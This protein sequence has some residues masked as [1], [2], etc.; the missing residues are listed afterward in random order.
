M[1]GI[2]ITLIMIVSSASC[3]PKTQPPVSSNYHHM[4]MLMQWPPTFCGRP[5][6][7]CKRSVIM[8]EFPIHGLWPGNATGHTP[9]TCNVPPN[10]TTVKKVERIG[11]LLAFFGVYRRKVMD[12]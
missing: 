8:L 4:Q 7:P 12:T 9:F 3:D 10:P 11:V 2:V 6:K 1:F 5:N